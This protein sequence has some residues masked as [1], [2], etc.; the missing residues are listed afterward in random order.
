[1]TF[2]PDTSQSPERKFQPVD[3]LFGSGVLAGNAFVFP[4]QIINL[5]TNNC[6]TLVLPYVNS[7]AIDCMAKHNNWGLIILPLSKLD[8]S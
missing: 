8:Y 6:A 1:S 5:R 2:T 4:H 7:L 3:Y